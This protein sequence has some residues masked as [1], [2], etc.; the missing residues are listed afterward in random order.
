MK[1]GHREKNISDLLKPGNWK[2]KTAK[3]SF[4]RVRG[5]VREE[6]RSPL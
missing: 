5:K 4:D 3:D 2:K 6:D 1:G